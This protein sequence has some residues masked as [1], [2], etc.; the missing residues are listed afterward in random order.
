VNGKSQSEWRCLV[1]AAGLATGAG[2]MTALLRLEVLEARLGTA[3]E[4]PGDAEEAIGIVHRLNNQI[5]VVRSLRQLVREGQGGPG[6]LGAA[7]A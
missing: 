6:V 3:A 5:Q 7:S 1:E 2:V 4:M